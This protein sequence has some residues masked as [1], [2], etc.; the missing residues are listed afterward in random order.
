[1]D[2]AV[3]RPRIEGSREQEIFEATLDLLVETG[4]DRLTLDSVAA[5]AKASKATLYRRWTS[6]AALVIDAVSCLKGELTELPDTGD[7]R[8]D[9]YAMVEAKGMGDPGRAGVFCGLGTAMYRDAE[10]SRRLREMI[11][12][13]RE[14]HLH[15]LLQR[16]RER[17]QLRADVDLDLIRKV[18]P[19]MMMFEAMF[20]S[21]GQIAE[22][23]VRR[24]IDH[25]LLPALTG[26]PQPGTG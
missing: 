9:L 18:L 16:A 17:G 21:P 10:L 14:D 26:C 15:R 22:G 1:M 6:K 20:E 25:L 13:P 5:R 24:V 23:Y 19:A 12:T 4:Y 8:S 2:A 7:L 11:F 3:T